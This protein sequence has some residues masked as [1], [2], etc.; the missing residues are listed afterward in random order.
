LSGNDFSRAQDALTKGEKQMRRTAA[1]LTLVT[2]V[3][4]LG[5]SDVRAGSAGTPAGK[6]TGASVTATIVMDL[7]GDCQSSQCDP[8]KG[9]TSI[10]IQRSGGSA[11][12]L[13]MSQKVFGVACP[14][15]LAD[16]NGRFVGLM[17]WVP[18]SVL[19]SLFGGSFGPKAVI[20]DTDY[21]SCTDVVAGAGG[22]A[23]QVLSFTAVIQ[24][25]K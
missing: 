8:N 18:G 12:A 16:I 13:F 9:L 25:V 1:I 4:L 21:A 15:V 19:G 23:R 14:D 22:G 7:T 10:R 20:T 6:T 3:S 5:A 24:F 2:V 17:G 11:A